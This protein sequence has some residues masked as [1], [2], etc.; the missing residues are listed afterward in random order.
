MLSDSSLT[1]HLCCSGA[2]ALRTGADSV[3]IF[4][5]APAAAVIRSY[6]SE[7]VIHPVLDQ[8]SVPEWFVKYL[9]FHEILHAALP[10]LHHGEA[11]ESTEG[12]SRRV[13][14]AASD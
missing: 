7:L 3:H 10:Q 5:E 11:P 4:C 14:P 1:S 9:L 12:R 13:T 6:S 8:R 2:A